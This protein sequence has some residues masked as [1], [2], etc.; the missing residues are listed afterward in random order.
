MHGETLDTQIP[1][2]LLL[3]DVQVSKS[4][5]DDVRR[6]EARLDPVREGGDVGTGQT[7]EE[8]DGHA[9]DVAAVARGGGIDVGVGVDLVMYMLSSAS[10]DNR[11]NLP[12]IPI[13]HR[14][15]GTWP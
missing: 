3:L 4:D 14:H 6:L 9:V 13:R 2:D 7:E 1:Q 10:E 15:Q 12:N 8:G 5:V 11:R